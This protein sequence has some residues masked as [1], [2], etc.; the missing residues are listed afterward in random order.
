MAGQGKDRKL[1]D[2]L[3]KSFPSSDPPSSGR[4]TATEP[5]GTPV[6]RKSPEITRAQVEQARSGSVVEGSQGA[7]PAKGGSLL[8]PAPGDD[9]PPG[10]RGTGPDVCPVCQGSGRADSLICANCDGQGNVTRAIGGA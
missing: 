7:E 2:A 9:A 3:T 5:T 4:A 10:T 6:G 1:D 8:R